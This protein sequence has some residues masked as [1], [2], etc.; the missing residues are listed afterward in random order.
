MLET[1]VAKLME[2]V[3]KLSRETASNKSE[4]SHYTK[5]LSSKDERIK[6]QQKE[7]EEY[8][9]RSEGFVWLLDVLVLNWFRFFFFLGFL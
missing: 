2:E 3:S 4:I 7:L 9:S 1:Q 8:A 6:Q 5:E